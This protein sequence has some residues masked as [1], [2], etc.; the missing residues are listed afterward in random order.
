MAAKKREGRKWGG[1]ESRKEGK[2]TGCQDFARCIVSLEE[3]F[4]ND[5]FV[6]YFKL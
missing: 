2:K 3:S 5:F 4:V 1:R 6:K